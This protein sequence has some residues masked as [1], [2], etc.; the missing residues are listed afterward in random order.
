MGMFKLNI[1][2]PQASTVQQTS[3]QAIHTIQ[4]TQKTLD[5]VSGEND[6]RIIKIYNRQSSYRLLP[7]QLRNQVLR[8]RQGYLF[9]VP[10]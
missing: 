2:G 1:H 10:Y 9:N 5:W 6:P 7:K 4:I 3:H 8:S